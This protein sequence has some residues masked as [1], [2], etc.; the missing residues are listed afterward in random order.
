MVDECVCVFP[1]DPNGRSDL[2]ET[3]LLT[4]AEEV[5]VREGVCVGV[6]VR[7]RVRACIVVYVYVCATDTVT[8]KK[9]FS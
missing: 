7:V 9:P 5:R 6:R 8:S 1:C 2:K 3:F 4:S